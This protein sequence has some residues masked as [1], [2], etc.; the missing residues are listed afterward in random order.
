[1]Y[2]VCM[3]VLIL[4]YYRDCL[5]RWIWLLV[6]CMISPRLEYGTRPFVKFFS[7]SNDFITPKVYFS[8]LI[9]VYVAS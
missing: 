5:T 6:T 4:F 2:H 3:T 9:R 8:R 7:C 1:M